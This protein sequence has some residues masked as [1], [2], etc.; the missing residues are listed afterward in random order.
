MRQDEPHATSRRAVL[1][2][3]AVLFAASAAGAT[4]PARDAEAQRI[5]ERYHSFGD[6]AAGGPGD[7]ASGEWLE[8]ELKGMGFTCRRQ[9]YDVPAF[10][11]E[12]TLTSG[13]ARADL[14][15]QAIVVTTQE[16]GLSGPLYV[17]G[18]GK[19]GPGIAL[20]VLPY[21]RWS[22]TSRRSGIS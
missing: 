20:L 12:A 6:K 17:A 10:E 4:T 18:A 9:T 2:A 5:L 3:P 14:I 7:T 16:A 22:R 21:A 19:S 1:G 13:T 15:P 8:G 11:G